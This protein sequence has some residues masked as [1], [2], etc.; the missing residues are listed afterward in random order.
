MD[1]GTIAGIIW[2]FFGVIAVVGLVAANVA[3]ASYF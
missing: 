2:L 1:E 3:A